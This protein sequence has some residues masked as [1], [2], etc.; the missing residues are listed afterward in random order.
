M[1]DRR[2]LVTAI[3]AAV[4][5]AVAAAPGV[6]WGQ[7]PLDGAPM[8]AAVDENCRATVNDGRRAGP[9]GGREARRAL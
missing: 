2:L 6:A 1:V 5:G 8:D 4:C 9:A 3:V 7:E